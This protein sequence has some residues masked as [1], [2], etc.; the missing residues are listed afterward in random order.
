MIPWALLKV[1]PWRKIGYVAAGVAMVAGALWYRHSL[2][3]SGDAAGAA[4]VQ[5]L[6]DADTTARKAAVDKA[7]AAVATRENAARAANMEIMEYANT[8]LVAIAADRDS[9]SG[10]L[11]SAEDRVRRLA[12]S[13]ATDHTL[14]DV[15]ARVAARQREIDALYDAYD[16]ACRR[17]AV[18]LD[19]L[20]REIRPQL[21]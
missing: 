18:R 12:S 17:D 6:W 7:I 11:R 16:R 20:Q 14:A 3:A 9:L 21:E 8:Q 13:E 4:R 15:A 19:A 1:L 10:L 5:A 2:I